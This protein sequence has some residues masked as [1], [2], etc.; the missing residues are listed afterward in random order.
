MQGDKQYS[1]QIMNAWAGSG[2]HGARLLRGDAQTKTLASQATQIQAGGKPL[3]H[4]GKRRILSCESIIPCG[5]V[6][7]KGGLNLGQ[8][9]EGK[10]RVSMQAETPKAIPYGSV[11]RAVGSGRLINRDECTHGR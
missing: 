8:L 6:A 7:A 1:D 3:V 9:Q 11:F 5:I 4:S 10:H 2:R